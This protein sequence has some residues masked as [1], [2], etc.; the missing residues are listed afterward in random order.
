MWKYL[1]W[2]SGSPALVPIKH[3]PVLTP[4]L[5]CHSYST[6]EIA[7]TGEPEPGSQ[8]V[9][10]HVISQKEFFWFPRI[11]LIGRDPQ[12]SSSPA[13]KWMAHTGIEPTTLVLSAPC[14]NELHFSSSGYWG[15]KGEGRGCGGCYRTQG[16]KIE[17]MRLNALKLFRVFSVEYICLLFFLFIILRT[18]SHLESLM[19]STCL[20]FIVVLHIV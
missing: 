9:T 18:V 5:L 12:G 15:T 3:F 7:C 8:A 10:S 19:V 11:F 4:S 6:K 16:N 13:F 2:L 17:V 1:V 14:F 20:I